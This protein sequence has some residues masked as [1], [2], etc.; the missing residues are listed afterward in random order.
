MQD[1]DQHSPKNS[2]N[3]PEDSIF[4]QL[5]IKEKKRQSIQNQNVINSKDFDSKG[6]K[7]FIDELDRNDEYYFK[8]RISTNLEHNLTDLIPVES[9]QEQLPAL[10]ANDSFSKLGKERSSFGQEANEK[11]PFL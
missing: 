8:R 2:G 11:N 4:E 7:D 9:P 1:A 10:H 3:Q 6:A 5:I